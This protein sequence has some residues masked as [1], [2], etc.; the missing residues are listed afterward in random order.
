MPAVP[1]L[2]H[3]LPSPPSA[4]F[5]ALPGAA[6]YAVLTYPVPPLLPPCPF[7]LPSWPP[8]AFD[9]LKQNATKAGIP[10]YGSYEETDPAIIAAKGVDTFKTEGRD[11]IIVDTSGGWRREGGGRSRGVVHV[12]WTAGWE[13]QEAVGRRGS[14]RAAQGRPVRCVPRKQGSSSCPPQTPQKG[15]HVPAK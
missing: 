1:A 15:K 3:P 6:C 11:L 7:P 10:F 14:S 2:L 5:R 13:E 12:L 4:S 9:Q 8:G